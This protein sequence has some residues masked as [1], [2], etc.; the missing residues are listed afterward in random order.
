MF[1]SFIRMIVASILIAYGGDPFIKGKEDDVDWIRLVPSLRDAA[2]SSDSS[3][4]DTKKGN[5]KSAF[6]LLKGCNLTEEFSF[7]YFYI[8]DVL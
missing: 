4:G 5:E 3:V 1:Y 2:S 8:F 7:S 6:S